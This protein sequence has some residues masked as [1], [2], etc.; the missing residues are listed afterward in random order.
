MRAL[1][2]LSVFNQYHRHEELNYR[3]R[4]G[5]GCDPLT[6]GT[7][8]SLAPKPSSAPAHQSGTDI[9]FRRTTYASDSRG[10]LKLGVAASG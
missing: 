7:H 3:V 1:P 4:N 6:L 5:N 9:R 2:T 8:R 10:M